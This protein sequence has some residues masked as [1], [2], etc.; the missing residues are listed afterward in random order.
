VR[1]SHRSFFRTAWDFVGSA[2]CGLVETLRAI[3]PHQRSAKFVPEE[4][5]AM[6]GSGRADFLS[7][8]Q[9]K[10]AH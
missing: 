3:L 7:A 8:R 10:K 1:E 4:L 5:I 2:F 6:V 9:W